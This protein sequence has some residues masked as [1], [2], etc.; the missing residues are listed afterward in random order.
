MFGQDQR[1]EQSINEPLY[2][3]YDHRSWHGKIG[4]LTSKSYPQGQKHTCKSSISQ[5]ACHD[6][7]KFCLHH[8]KVLYS[9][10]EEAL[11]CKT[12]RLNCCQSLL[13]FSAT[14][15]HMKG[16][17]GYAYNWYIN[18]RRSNPCKHGLLA[19]PFSQAMSGTKW[20]HTHTNPY[21][22]YKA[23]IQN[24]NGCLCCTNVSLC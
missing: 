24:L 20:N 5:C 12:N 8:S 23:H 11:V 17:G 9:P 4:A 3:V 22:V 21:S 18:E 13:L 19:Q 6:M 14:T 2:S 10:L 15:E 16:E 1:K 7:S